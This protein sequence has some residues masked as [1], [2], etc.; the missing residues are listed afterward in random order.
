MSSAPTPST[1]SSTTTLPG[2]V[3]DEQHCD[4][5]TAGQRTELHSILTRSGA[6]AAA[7]IA[8]TND[9]VFG[10]VDDVVDKLSSTSLLD[11]LEHYSNRTTGGR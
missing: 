11:A 7:S 1:R 5:L 10:K 3:R 4:D 2:P 6:L 8:A 9:L